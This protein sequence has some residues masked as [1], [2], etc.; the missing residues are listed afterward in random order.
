MSTQTVGFSLK[1]NTDISKFT[2]DVYNQVIVD[3]ANAVNK[4]PSEVKITSLKNGS[5]LVEGTID[6]KSSE[7]GATA[8]KSLNTALSVGAKIAGQE[9]IESKFVAPAG[10]TNTE[11]P[12]PTPTPK[13]NPDQ[14]G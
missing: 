5:V 14:T 6:T 4:S 7:D 9:I 1:L 3:L 13:P 8:L 2:T 11:N 12:T 10:S